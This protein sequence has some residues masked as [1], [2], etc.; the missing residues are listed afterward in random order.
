MRRYL[1]IAAWALLAAIFIFTVGPLSLRPDTGLPPDLERF[2]ALLV[3]GVA[4]ALAHP[5]HPLFVTALIFLSIGILE[6]LQVF[7][8]YRHGTLHDALI[9]YAGGAVG[10]L[11]GLLVHSFWSRKQSSSL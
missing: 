11:T 8:H 1:A 10:V 7:I 2:A 3:V 4:F 9:K 5:K 6:F